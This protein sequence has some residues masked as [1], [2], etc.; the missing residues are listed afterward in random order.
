VY[1]EAPY[2]P[3]YTGFDPE[4]SLGEEDAANL[5]RWGFNVVRLGVLWPGVEPER[6]V[7]NHTYLEAIDDIIAILARHGIYTMVDFHQDL[8]TRKFCGEGIPAWVEALIL[9]EIPQDTRPF[10]WPVGDRTPSPFTQWSVPKVSAGFQALYDNV[11]GVLDS[12]AEYW[13]VVAR[14]FADSPWVIGYDLINE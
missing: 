13:R 7:Y 1:K 14:W 8:L 5:A 3:I 12:L 4:E 2:H 11:G 10:P 6:G 9:E